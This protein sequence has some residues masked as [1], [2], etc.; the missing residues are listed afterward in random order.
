MSSLLWFNIFC[1]SLFWPLVK[2]KKLE[3]SSR[4]ML[5]TIS[6][7]YEQLGTKFKLAYIVDEREKG[8]L[9]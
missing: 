4:R 1:F 3:H 6:Y 2:K 9:F 5:T 7:K 8:N